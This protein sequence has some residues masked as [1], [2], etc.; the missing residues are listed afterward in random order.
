LQSL[1]AAVFDKVKSQQWRK[2]WRTKKS[3]PEAKAT[4]I[5]RWTK[6][7]T[8]SGGEDDPGEKMGRD[9]RSVSH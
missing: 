5:K 2:K 4:R 9:T 6:A 8:T 7:Q 3:T 1:S